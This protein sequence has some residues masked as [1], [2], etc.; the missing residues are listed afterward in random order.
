MPPESPPSEIT[1]E[2]I[3]EQLNK[4]CMG[5]DPHIQGSL[6][7][8]LLRWLIAIKA[9]HR[10]DQKPKP[11]ARQIILEFYDY[12]EEKLGIKQPKPRLGQN[13]RDV[14]DDIVAKGKQ[15]FG[16]LARDLSKY[17]REQGVKDGIIITLQGKSGGGYEPHF[18]RGLAAVRPTQDDDLLQAFVGTFH[19]YHLSENDE[20]QPTWWYK[21]LT[22]L[23]GESAGTLTGRAWNLP[24]AG[25]PRDKKHEYRYRVSLDHGHLILRVHRADQTP[26]VAVTVFPDARTLF[27]LSGV[28]IMTKTWA[29]RS[30]SSICILSDS[31]LE[32][33]LGAIDGEP[34]SDREIIQRLEAVW[35]ERAQMVHLVRLPTVVAAPLDAQGI[36]AQPLW[37]ETIFLEALEHS[38]DDAEIRLLTTFFQNSDLLDK[39][40]RLLRKTGSTRR[41]KVLLIDP[42]PENSVILEKAVRDWKAWRAGIAR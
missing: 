21:A 12:A 31:E 7:R 6:R 4:L 8:E 37:D 36:I 5:T 23:P 2:E 26:D 35:E 13:D 3:E 16:D 33:A 41:V 42:R 14:Q 38:P 39:L 24:K 34:I 18:N 25:T 11:T 27:P 28:A 30:V 20:R 15:L 1:S 10:Y 17:Y 29:N 22:L 19:L 9:A 32:C 40:Q